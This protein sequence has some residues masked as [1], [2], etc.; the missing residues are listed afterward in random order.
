M[1]ENLRPG[2]KQC[3]LEHGPSLRVQRQARYFEVVTDVMNSQAVFKTVSENPLAVALFISIIKR[4]NQYGT[5]EHRTINLDNF[6]IYIFCDPSALS[7]LRAPTNFTFAIKSQ[8]KQSLFGK[9]SVYVHYLSI[10][11]EALFTN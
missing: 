4:D 3:I 5:K 2:H 8:H 9:N 1:L 6:D 10:N 11:N 7:K